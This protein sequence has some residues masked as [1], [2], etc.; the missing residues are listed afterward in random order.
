MQQLLRCIF[1]A[2]LAAILAVPAVA[3]TLGDVF[4]ID[5]E[6]HNFTQ[7]AGV[8][9]PQPL[10]GN[11]AAPFQNS[12]ITPGNPNAAHVRRYASNY[13]N[14]RGSGAPFLPNI[15]GR[16]GAP[17]AACPLTIRPWEPAARTR[18]MPPAFPAF[19]KQRASLGSRIRKTSTWGLPAAV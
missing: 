12:L 1:A 14:A 18:A 7:P 2:S 16:N 15:S 17:A 6:N 9:S 19:F 10:L 11:T 4:Y 13:Q 3:G 8:T 5:M